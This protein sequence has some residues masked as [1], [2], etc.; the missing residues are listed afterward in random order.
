MYVCADN[1]GQPQQKADHF[2]ANY[3]TRSRIA[4]I[5]EISRQHCGENF[6]LNGRTSK[7]CVFA[8]VLPTFIYST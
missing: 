7:K 4:L 2:L 3:F 1:S 5:E 6:S 8:T